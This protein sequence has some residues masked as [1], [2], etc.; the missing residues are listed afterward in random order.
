[1][2]S[3]F[4]EKDIVYVNSANRSEGTSSDFNIELSGQIRGRN[5][6]DSVSLLNLSMPKS[7]YLFNSN[8]NT[9]TVN[10]NGNLTTITIPVGNYTFIGPLNI[11]SD[12]L[13]NLFSA[14]AWTY[15]VTNNTVKG[16][17]EFAVSGNGGIQPIFDF[18]GSASPYKVLGFAKQQY[19]FTANSLSSPD[20]VDFQLTSSIKLCCD[21]TERGILS[22]IVPNVQDLAKISYTEYNTQYVSQNLSVSNIT[23]ARFYIIDATTDLPLDLNGQ[24][25]TFSFVIFKKNNYYFHMLEDRKLELELLDLQQKMNELELR[26]Q[27]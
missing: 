20:V 26:S 24:D 1:M 11:L 23:S 15:T 6:Y 17:F 14:C 5:N 21:F 4:L 13:T 2:S 10:E 7:Y 27:N 12:I 25:Y 19:A 8:N 18:S 9:F 22:F 3:D 16:I